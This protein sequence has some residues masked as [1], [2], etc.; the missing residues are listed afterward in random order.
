MKKTFNSFKNL[1]LGEKIGK[2]LFRL[3]CI[4]AGAYLGASQGLIE[5]TIIGSLI[6]G[7]GTVAG[8]VIGAICGALI[9]AGI[10]ALFAKYTAK[11]MSWC[12]NHNNENAISTTNP[13]KYQVALEKLSERMHSKTQASIML[14]VLREQKNRKI[15]FPGTTARAEK[16]KYNELIRAI[17][18]DK[19]VLI[20][21]N[22]KGYVTANSFFQWENDSKWQNTLYLPPLKTNP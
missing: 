2:S 10:G 3:S 9:T 1:F 8:A 18:E 15:T 14:T 19:P 4:G 11:F 22:L 6:P 16:N 5:G 12:F 20:N 21:G 7:L 17:A 13:E